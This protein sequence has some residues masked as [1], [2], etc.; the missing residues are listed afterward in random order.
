M[1]RMQIRRGVRWPAGV[2]FGVPVVPHR[3]TG[4]PRASGEKGQVMKLTNYGCTNRPF[5]HI[6]VT[7]V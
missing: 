7:K 5:Y 3:T 4:A 6:E 2:D 1:V